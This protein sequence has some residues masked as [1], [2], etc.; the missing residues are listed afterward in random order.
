MWHNSVS[1]CGG[2]PIL[3]EGNGMGIKGRRE[4]KENAETEEWG[5]RVSL[6]VMT[7]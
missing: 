1:P 3:N 7:K 6:R 5:A 4:R 2:L